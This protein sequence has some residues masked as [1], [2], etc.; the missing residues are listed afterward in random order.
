MRLKL[1]LFVLLLS[2]GVL[3]AQDTI[4][5]LIISEFTMGS[6]PSSYFEI[7]N[8]GD[9]A[10]NLKVIEWGELRP[11]GESWEKWQP[12]PTRRFMLPDYILEPGASFVI[13]GAFDFEPK[14]YAKGLE[15]YREKVTKDDMEHSRY[16]YS[17]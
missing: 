8:M 9:V 15:G 5:G 4:R 6:Q 13:S 1:L 7:T 16:A 11:W 17:Y 10:V 2:G 12:D 3:S 14:Q